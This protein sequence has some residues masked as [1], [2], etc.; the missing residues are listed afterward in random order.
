MG[1]RIPLTG[2][3]M[4]HHPG[5][6]FEKPFVSWLERTLV[7]VYSRRMGG[8]LRSSRSIA[9]RTATRGARSATTGSGPHV[10][11]Q[12]RTLRVRPP[13]DVRG[14]PRYYDECAVRHWPVCGPLPPS[15]VTCTRTTLAA[16]GRT[17]VTQ[18]ATGLPRRSEG[19]LQ[20]RARSSR[21]R[22]GQQLVA[23]VDE[24]RVERRIHAVGR[25][26]PELVAQAHVDQPG[27]AG[28]K[29]YAEHRD[30]RRPARPTWAAAER[31]RAP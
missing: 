27:S 30:V 6:N 22:H 17:N 12:T 25:P 19:R 4:R 31:G 24:L 9:R 23:A 10:A 14:A 15:S 5:E 16:V 29:P 26:T 8:V 1:C 18:P 7:S 11:C 13:G 2:T 3:D 28:A 20:R 21:A